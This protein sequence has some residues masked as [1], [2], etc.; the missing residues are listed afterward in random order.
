MINMRVIVSFS[1]HFTQRLESVK[2]GNWQTAAAQP[3]HLTQ[4]AAA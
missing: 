4:R 1:S 3:D 2:A